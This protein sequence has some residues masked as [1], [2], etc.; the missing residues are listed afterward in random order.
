VLMMVS[1]IVVRSEVS[2]WVW[3]RAF[4]LVLNHFQSSNA[5]YLVVHVRV[6]SWIELCLLA[7][8]DWVYFVSIMSVERQEMS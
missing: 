1:N 5:V 8:A 2:R 3:C 4:G 7:R 6:L